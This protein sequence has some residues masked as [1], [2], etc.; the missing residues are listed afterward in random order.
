MAGGSISGRFEVAAAGRN[1]LSAALLVGA[2]DSKSRVNPQRMKSL[3][4][5]HNADSPLNAA[6]QVFVVAENFIAK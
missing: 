5:I 6:A 2:A 4:A 1:T 3:R